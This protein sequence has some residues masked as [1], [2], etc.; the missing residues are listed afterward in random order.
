MGYQ[1]EELRLEIDGMHCASCAARVERGLNQVEGVAANVNY[2]TEQATVHRAPDVP[3][4][5]LIGAVE[6]SGYHAR[7]TE[8]DHHPAEPPGRS[9]RLA[10]AV[11]LA[12]PVALLGMLSQLHFAH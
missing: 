1:T 3:V 7:A 12:V 11:A 4:E 8:G 10:V 9:R 2:L 5:R 6:A